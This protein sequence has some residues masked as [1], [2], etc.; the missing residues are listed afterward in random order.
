MLRATGDD[1]NWNSWAQEPNFIKTLQS[2][3]SWTHVISS[4]HICVAKQHDGLE[5]QLSG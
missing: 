5:V 3:A 4:R 1:D 2:Q